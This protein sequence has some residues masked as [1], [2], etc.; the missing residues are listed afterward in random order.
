[1]WLRLQKRMAA[2]MKKMGVK[3][4]LIMLVVLLLLFIILVVLLVYT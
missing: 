2:V 3:G 1:V 4:Q